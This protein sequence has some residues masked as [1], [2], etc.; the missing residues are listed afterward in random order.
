MVFLL[1]TGVDKFFEKA[2]GG[3]EVMR[4]V[5]GLG[6]EERVEAVDG[7]ELQVEILIL[8]HSRF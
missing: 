8:L 7:L 1:V 4:E 6:H 3:L 2:A 5:L